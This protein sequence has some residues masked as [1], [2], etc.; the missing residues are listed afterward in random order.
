MWTVSEF[1]MSVE[2]GTAGEFPLPPRKAPEDWRSPRPG[3]FPEP[4]SSGRRSENR[5]N[6]IVP[7]GYVRNAW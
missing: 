3:G 7:R 5:Y 2:D 1:R 6:A 4:D